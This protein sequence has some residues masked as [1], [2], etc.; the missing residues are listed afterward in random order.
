MYIFVR[1]D[2]PLPHQIVQS[3]HATLSMASLHGFDGIPNIVLIGVPDKAALLRA[4]D[5]CWE[6]AIPHYLWR[7][8]DFDFGETAIATAA[9]SGAKREA[10]AQYRLWKE[11]IVHPWPKGKAADSNPV[12]AGSTPAG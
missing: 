6:N 8:P 2:I 3:N 5:Q 10:F 7:E 12:H 4:A 9:I 11:F 1:Q